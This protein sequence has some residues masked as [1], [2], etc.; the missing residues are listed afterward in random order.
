MWRC[1][2]GS[3][4]PGTSPPSTGGVVPSSACPHRPTP[5]AGGG[6]PRL[7]ALR[8]AKP[9]DPNKAST[10]S[11]TCKPNV[12]SAGGSRGFVAS[13]DL[14]KSPKRV[15]GGA[16]NHHRKVEPTQLREERDDRQH[17]LRRVVAAPHGLRRQEGTVRLR[18][19]AGERQR[20]GRCPEPGVRI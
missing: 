16:G 2:G 3:F 19:H 17:V 4:P 18:D 5:G 20:L 7:A 1:A 9:R 15:L 13:A 14:G 8:E 10:S 12:C 11:A 6:M